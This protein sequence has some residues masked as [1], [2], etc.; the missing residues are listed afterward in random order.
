VVDDSIVVL[1]NIYRHVQEGE[2]V[3]SAVITG[4]RE[5]AVAI[6]GATMPTVAVFL[7]LGFAGG[8]VGIMFRPFALT[9]TVALLASLVIALTIVPILARFLIRRG[10]VVRR[11]VARD[12]GTAAQRAYTPVL[13]WALAHRAITLVTAAVIFVGSL[14]LAS[15][16]PTALMSHGGEKQ[17]SADISLPPEIA[18]PDLAIEKAIEAEEIIANLPGVEVYSTSIS[19][20]AGADQDIFSLGRLFSGQGVL[21]ASITVTLHP[22][23]DLEAVSALARERLGAMGGALTSV[24]GTGG[25]DMYSALDVSVTGDDPDAVK[26]AA[27]EILAAVRDTPGIVDVASAA[28]SQRAEIAVEVDPKLALGAGVT[29]AQVAMLIRELTIGQTVTTLKVD[30]ESLDVV[31]RADPDAVGTIEALGNITVGSFGDI[32]IPLSSIAKIERRDAPAHITH[33]NT[34]PSASVTG[35][36]TAEDTGKVN[37]DIRDR[38]DSI[39]LPPGVEVTYGGIQAMFADA[40]NTLYVGIAASVVIVYIVMVLVMGSLL[41]PFVIM[42][43]LPLASI[44]ALAALAITG[45]ALSMS[46]LFGILMLVGIVVTNGIVLIDFVNQLRSRGMSVYDALMEGGRLRLRPVLMTAVTTILAMIPIA[47][48]FTEGAIMAAELATVVIGGLFTS[49]LLTL[50]VVPVVYSLMESLR[51]RFAP[52]PSPTPEPQPAPATD[53]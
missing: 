11:L 7:P 21:G 50:V 48:G 42:F 1:E 19:L 27:L 25:E 4:T 8:M 5:V 41:S 3:H 29:G 51:H 43:T 18:T 15:V 37:R 45:R 44:G 38:V 46:S 13:R 14:G 30:G 28:I 23:A 39:Q 22:D 31:M 35:T 49:T 26:T 9:I 20:G 53:A 40:F 52:A 16:I 17:F 36:I 33:L 34:K 32:S 47:L 6:F 24:A 10:R 12:R 2:D